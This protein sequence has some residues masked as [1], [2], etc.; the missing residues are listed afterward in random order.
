[1]NDTFWKYWL[2]PWDFRVEERNAW[3]SSIGLGTSRN[4]K[5][6]TGASAKSLVVAS[7]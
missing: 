6:N 2:F 3:A 5:I 7:Y 4:I 1:M